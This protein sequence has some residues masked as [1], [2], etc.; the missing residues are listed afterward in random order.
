MRERM[1]RTES[2]TTR[3]QGGTTARRF[4]G[5]FNERRRRRR[6]HRR[7]GV[8]GGGQHHQLNYW[9]YSDV[10]IVKTWRHNKYEGRRCFHFGKM[11]TAGSCQIQ[12][13]SKLKGKQ[14]KYRRE[15]QLAGK[16]NSR[17][18]EI[19]V[20][21]KDWRQLLLSTGIIHVSC[22]TRPFLLNTK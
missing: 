19:S 7:R 18:R 22:T 11:E 16:G 10:H 20:S 2:E 14:K 21:W 17:E 13:V 9:L 4:N 1:R 15:K 12:L 8:G 3:N 5:V 6:R